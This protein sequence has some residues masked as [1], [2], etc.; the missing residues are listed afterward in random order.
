MI[1]LIIINNALIIKTLENSSSSELKDINLA[2]LLVSSLQIFYGIDMLIFESTIL[3]SFE[4]MYEGTGYMLCVG[5]L[6]YPFLPTILSKYMFFRRTQINYLFAIPILT[7]IIGYIIY[8]M[9]NSQKNEFRKNPYSPALDNLETISTLRGKRLIASGFWGYVRHPNY[10]GD[11]IMQWSVSCLSMTSELLPYYAP[12]CC[13]IILMH[14]AIR[15]N[16]R[17]KLRYDYA[18][19]QYCLRVKYMI[20][21]YVF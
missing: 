14:R 11:I 5:H 19:E 2:Q 15:D 10:L 7:F 4:I 16:K 3:T 13:T 20:L 9:S 21:N 8:R 18:W 6:L 17:C 12:L 1:G